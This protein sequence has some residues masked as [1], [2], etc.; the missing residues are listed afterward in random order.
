[1]A[2]GCFRRRYRL[3]SSCGLGSA[4]WSEGL[5]A[6]QH[7]SHTRVQTRVPGI[8]RRTLMSHGNSRK[9]PPPPFKDIYLASLGLSCSTRD[10]QLCVWNLVP[11]PG[12]VPR[13]LHWGCGILATGPPGK[14]LYDVFLGQNFFFFQKPQS[15]LRRPLT[16]WMRPVHS[17]RWWW[18]GGQPFYTK[19]MDLNVNHI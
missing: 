17:M 10:L 1:M 8:G 4:V 11:R 6:S 15:F 12:V 9:S 18:W 2:C 16:D 7:V 13:A 14:S 19:S 5:A 3:L